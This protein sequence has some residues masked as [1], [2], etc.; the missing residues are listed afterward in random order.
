MEGRF[1]LLFEDP[2]W[3]GYFERYDESGCQ[4]ARFVFGAEPGNAELLQFAHD[5]FA[6]LKFVPTAAS[7]ISS[8][9]SV[10]YKRRQRQLRQEAVT[11]RGTYAQR[12]FQAGL[13]AA[14]AERASARRQHKRADRAEQYQIKRE[15]KK[16]Q[17]G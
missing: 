6:Q 15:K 16:K 3:I 13:E 2:Y 1:T 11:P 12:L 8:T 14:Q 5:G 9:A 4:V 17:R 7:P 10:G